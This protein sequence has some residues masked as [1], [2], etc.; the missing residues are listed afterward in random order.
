LGGN[1]ASTEAVAH[2]LVLNENEAAVGLQVRAEDPLERPAADV[3]VD[4]DEALS[5]LGSMESP[6]GKPG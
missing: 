1:G 4:D 2:R 5:V 3:D 6:Y